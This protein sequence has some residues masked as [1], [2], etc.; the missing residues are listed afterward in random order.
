MENLYMKVYIFALS[1]FDKEIRADLT[2]RN[3]RQ[4]YKHLILL[5]LYPDTIYVEHWRKEVYNFEND[6]ERS[7]KNNRFPKKKFIQQ[8]LSEC[9]DVIPQ[10]VEQAKAKMRKENITPKYF[11]TSELQEDI[12]KYIDWLSEQ[13]SEKGYV[14]ED[15]V[16]EVLEQLGF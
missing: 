6:V 7:K 14:I 16:I 12:A 5:K 15:E 11:T 10:M 9:M 13:L 8:C 3:Q 4:M 1:K 2:D